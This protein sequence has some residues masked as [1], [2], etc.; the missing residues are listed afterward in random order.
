MLD[1]NALTAKR[2][3]EEDVTIVGLGT[4]RVRGL[5]RI[6]AMHVQAANDDPAESDRRVIA[7]GMVTPSLVVPGLLHQ[8]DGKRCRAC[9]DVQLWQEA[10]VAGELEDVTDAI[11]RLSG[12]GGKA[13][14]KAAYKSTP[15]EP[16][17]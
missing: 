1:V 8:L 17:A 14:E 11:G 16:V 7:Q 4:V 10:A 2:I 12:M 15:G 3:P 5:N 9:A 13:A 6:E